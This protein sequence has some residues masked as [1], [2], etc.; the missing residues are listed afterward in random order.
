M[1]LMEMIIGGMI[2]RNCNQDV[3]LPPE[4]TPPIYDTFPDIIF[5]FTC[6]SLMTHKHNNVMWSAGLWE[7]AEVLNHSDES[8]SDLVSHSPLVKMCNGFRLYEAFTLPWVQPTVWILSLHCVSSS[9]CWIMQWRMSAQSSSNSRYHIH[10]EFNISKKLQVK[11]SESHCMKQTS[12]ALKCSSLT[13]LFFIFFAS[14]LL[15]V[16]CFALSTI[17]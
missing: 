2:N 12:H 15:L 1:F 13:L 8:V 5:S 17:L 16:K 10:N 6:C 9:L 7:A 4:A 3:F 11:I 14:K